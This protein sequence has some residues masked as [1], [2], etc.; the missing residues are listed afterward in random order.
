MVV[1]GVQC[2]VCLDVSVDQYKARL[3]AKGFTQISGKDFNATF[4]PVAKL[5]TIQIP[6]SLAASY[7][8]LFH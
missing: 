5:N 7:S 1:N 2:E 6:V 8:C 4:V 3:V